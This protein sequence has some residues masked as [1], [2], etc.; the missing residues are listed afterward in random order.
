MQDIFSASAGTASSLL[1]HEGQRRRF[2]EQ[3]QFAGAFWIGHIGRIQKD[4]AREQCTV[5]I[6]HQGADIPSL[7]RFVVRVLQAINVASHPRAPG[8]IIPLIGAVGTATFRHMNIFMR[9]EKL[10]ETRIE[11]I[12]MHAVAV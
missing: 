5:K 1:S 9:Q 12:A 7:I 10:A 2:I 3:A 8:M 4:P 6:G 11:G